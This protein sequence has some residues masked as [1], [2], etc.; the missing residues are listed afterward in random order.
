M[1]RFGF[2]LG[3]SFFKRGA[4]EVR[5]S[6]ALSI[7]PTPIIRIEEKTNRMALL[8]RFPKARLRGESGV[9]LDFIF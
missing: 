8:I 6:E 5:Q 9:K 3:P 7:H 2:G 1:K 4:F